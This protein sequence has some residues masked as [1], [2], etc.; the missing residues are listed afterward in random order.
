MKRLISGLVLSF[1]FAI[2]AASA[3]DED[4]EAQVLEIQKQYADGWM[5]GDVEAMANV[6]TDDAVYWPETGGVFEGKDAIRGQLAMEVEQGIP[7]SVDIKS[8]RVE[9]LGETIVDVGTFSAN[10]ESIGEIRGEYVVLGEETAD[11]IRVHRLIAFPPR[12]APEA[13]GQ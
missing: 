10:I 11:G 5:A 13:G 7:T 2:A 12:E 9:R 4:L 3:Q 6:F 1:L 8:S